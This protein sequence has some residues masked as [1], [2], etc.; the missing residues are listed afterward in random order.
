MLLIET[1]DENC[2]QNKCISFIH[3]ICTDFEEKILNKKAKKLFI[4]A[5][6]RKTNNEKNKAKGEMAPYL[7]SNKNVLFS[8]Y[9]Y[10]I[11]II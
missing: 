2:M 8:F 9:T 6:K 4:I 7:F 1:A 11:H 5:M 3:N 10:D